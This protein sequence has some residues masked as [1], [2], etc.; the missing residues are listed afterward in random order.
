MKNSHYVPRFILKKF[1]DRLCLYNIKTKEYK[2]NVK[3]EKAYAAKGFYDDVI[4]DNLNLK[5]ESEFSNFLSERILK[6]ESTIELSRKELRLIK[7][8]LLIS[9]MRSVG[10]E[11]FVQKEKYFYESLGEIYERNGI[12]KNEAEKERPFIE[13]KIPSET[14]REYWLR[15]INVILDTDG[16][17]KKF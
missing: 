4:E 13:V 2:E 15:T 12:D 8:F 5:I 9:I 16:S 14:N 7:K 6:C 10:T 3:P 1:S 17:Q 11:D